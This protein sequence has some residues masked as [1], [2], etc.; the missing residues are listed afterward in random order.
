MR[1]NHRVH[2]PRANSSIPQ[3]FPVFPSSLL[4]PGT[5]GLTARAHLGSAGPTLLLFPLWPPLGSL[6]L[7]RLLPSE[8]D[9]QLCSREYFIIKGYQFMV[10]VYLPTHQPPPP[11][12]ELHRISSCSSQSTYLVSVGHKAGSH[13]QAPF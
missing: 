4:C 2:C 3:L 5:E 10:S 11:H 8:G 1:S 12:C 9:T 7:S 6:S 13:Y